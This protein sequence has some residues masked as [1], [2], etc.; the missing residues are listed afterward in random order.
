MTPSTPIESP[1]ETESSFKPIA[2]AKTDPPVASDPLLKGTTEGRES[3]KNIRGS[4]LLLVG[5]L[6][7]KFL[8]FLV[9]VLIVRYLTQSDYGAFA[10]A[11]SLVG[12]GEH[13][14]TF[15]FHRAIDRFVPVYQ[16]ERAFD[17]MAGTVL[18]AFGSVVG[19]ATAAILILYGCFDWISSNL[20]GN[21]QAASLLLIMIFLSPIE[22][23]DN[24]L[25]GMFAVFAGPRAIFARRYV[26]AP[27]LKLA[28]VGIVTVGG[29]GVHGMAFGYVLGGLI[30][31]TFY[32]V[33]LHH[34]LA[35][36]GLLQ[37][38][39]IR[40]VAVPW[41]EILS[42]TMPM[43][44]ID[45]FYMVTNVL[46]VWMLD[47]YGS[48]NEVA[49]FRAVVPVA[50]LNQLVF[51]TFTLLYGPQAAKMYARK[52]FGSINGL[53]W[54]TAVWIA[55]ISFPIFVLTFSLAK[56]L[57]IQLFGDRYASSA[58]VLA[59]LSLG[60][61]VN[62]ALGFNGK[63]LSIYKRVGYLV[64]L[65]VGL[66][67]INLLAVWL[68]VPRYGALG[69]AIATGGTLILHNLGKQ[70]GLIT[71]GTGINFFE[72]NYLRVY[73]AIS[74]V[75]ASLFGLQYLLGSSPILCVL[76]TLLASLLVIR[77]CRKQLDV[78][79]VF[80]ELAKVPLLRA[81]LKH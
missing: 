33:V 79:G 81:F 38:F 7:S 66:A 26:I 41:R 30:G 14:G 72:W 54:Q 28:V 76:L 48:A 55:I 53:Y 69:A 27:L 64:R 51:S 35:T 45:L 78:D 11:I 62:A 24:L 36:S 8:N 57:T 63:T 16:E 40:T 59:I 60:Q 73:L 1:L 50:M 49:A 56:P 13:L 23:F 17:K 74:G 67:V 31:I 6:V 61:Y 39:R 20:I 10:Y 80:P 68:L 29:L 71:Q 12:L 25:T 22:S 21:E 37:H 75:A 4:S 5:R 70:V 32:L 52:D 18:L 43:L 9:H 19:I 65:N 77:L 34:V 46:V 44:S 2:A 47:H 58:E 3:R 42:F 15:G